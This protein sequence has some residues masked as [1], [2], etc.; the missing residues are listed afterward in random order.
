MPLSLR[1]RAIAVLGAIALLSPSLA[2]AAAPGS[3][4]IPG[5]KRTIGVG[6]IDV[7]GTY[8]NSSATNAGGAIA[9]S[10]TTRLQASRCCDVVERDALNELVTEM[11]LAKSGVSTGTAAPRPGA[12]LPAQY[13]VVGSVTAQSTND[14]GAGL[15]IG[16]G[17][18]ALNIGGSQGDIELDLRLV[19]TRT[20]AVVAAFKVRHK[21][22]S[23]AIGLTTNVSGV[24]VGPNAFFNTPQ[25]KA[26]DAALDDAVVEI[27]RAL[28][29]QPWRGQVVKY[30]GG[31]VW[32]ND[33]GDGGV[34]VG[35][36]FVVERAGETLTD[37]ATGKVLQQTMQDLGVVTITDVQ[38]AIAWGSYKATLASDPAR[39]DFLL[40]QPR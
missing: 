22:T 20:S 28:A 3:I 27:E 10:L 6:A 31:V 23:R 36:T 15:S 38:P 18:T 30:D 14:R 29:A 32:V 19:D 17:A 26:T 34:H 9:A 8:A 1:R 2:W 24:S 7:I 33:G 25:G 39:G 5:P 11:D 16:T 40:M 21:I 35:D 37:P 4:T 13:I 12:V